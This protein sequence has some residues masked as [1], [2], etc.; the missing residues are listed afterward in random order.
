MLNVCRMKTMTAKE[1]EKKTNDMKIN[2]TEHLRGIYVSSNAA[3]MQKKN[4]SFRPH[5]GKNAKM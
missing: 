3:T 4:V 2:F 5:G 1:K